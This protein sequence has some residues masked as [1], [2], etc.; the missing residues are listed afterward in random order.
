LQPSLTK[1]GSWIKKK[2]LQGGSGGFGGS[3]NTRKEG[4]NQQR[5]G[6]TT[7]AKRTLGSALGDDFLVNQT[8][9]SHCCFSS[10]APCWLHWHFVEVPML[11]EKRG[12]AYVSRRTEDGQAVGYLV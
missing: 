3:H 2:T 8:S 10:L 5:R 4:N 7:N 1:R 6:W 9:E 12:K 11:P